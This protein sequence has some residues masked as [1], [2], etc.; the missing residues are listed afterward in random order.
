MLN[1]VSSSCGY[2]VSG[3]LYPPR[4]RR[5]LAV[6]YPQINQRSVV[7]VSRVEL[8][9]QWEERLRAFRASGQ[10][11]ASWCAA[12]DISVATFHYWLRRFPPLA[13]TTHSPSTSTPVRFLEL[14]MTP[15]SVA[16]TSS[17]MVRIGEVTID[18][19]Q[20]FDPVLLRQVVAALTTVC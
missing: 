20:D 16:H 4:G 3:K 9:R 18:V 8:R 15:I 13:Q 10:G 12:H 1:R 6:S 11:V 5:D 14:D 7:S 17:L 19:P 2:Q